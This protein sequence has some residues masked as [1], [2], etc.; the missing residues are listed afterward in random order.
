MEPLMLMRRRVSDPQSADSTPQDLDGDSIA[1]LWMRTLTVMD[2]STPP[3]TTRATT[4]LQKTPEPTQ[5][6]PIPMA[7][8]FATVQTLLVASVRPV[9]MSS[10][11]TLQ[12][13]WTPMAMACLTTLLMAYRQIWWLTI[14]TT[15]TSGRIPMSWPV[16]PTRRT[17][18]VFRS[19]ATLTVF[20]MRLMKRCLATPR[21][22]PR[23]KSSKPSS[24][25]QASSS[26][27]T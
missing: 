4:P 21:M 13:R 3:K 26:S 24:T 15:A 27:P 11:T 7:T 18:Q 8:V 10:H 25:N 14:T 19:T 9:P 2:C 23:A 1:M 12:H 16:E 5:P 20:V 6:T 22:E 17:V